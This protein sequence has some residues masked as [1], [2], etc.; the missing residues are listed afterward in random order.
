[1]INNILLQSNSWEMH[2]KVSVLTLVCMNVF[3]SRKPGVR[4]RHCWLSSC[5]TDSELL[6][7]HK[8]G[9]AHSTQYTN[10]GQY[11][12]TLYLAGMSE[13]DWRFHKI[14]LVVV[15]IWPVGPTVPGSGELL[16]E[17]DYKSS[18]GD[19]EQGTVLQMFLRDSRH[20]QT[21]SY[22]CKTDQQT[23]LFP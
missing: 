15:S 19:R 13:W 5:N 23:K 20:S 14:C 18:E 10:L 1:M 16:A 21:F 7:C 8:H 9:T 12:N 17:N 11:L 22:R 6:S 3:L 4:L 2:P